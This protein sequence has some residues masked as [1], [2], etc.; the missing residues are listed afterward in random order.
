MAIIQDYDLSPPL[1]GAGAVAALRNKVIFGFASGSMDIQP[2]EIVT[3]SVNATLLTLTVLQFPSNNDA[4]QAAIDIEANDF[5]SQADLNHRVPLDRY[6]NAHSHSQSGVP[7]LESTI[8]HGQYIV[9][10]FTQTPGGDINALKSLTEKAFDRQIAM[11]DHLPPLSPVEVIKQDIDPDRMLRR[12]LN[13]DEDWEPDP[14]SLAAYDLQGFLQFQA[15]P[16]SEKRLYQSLHIEKFGVGGSYFR[17]LGDYTHQGL[18]DGFQSGTVKNLQGDLLYRSPNISSAHDT[19]LKILNAP[20][21]SMT[22]KNVPDT[23]CAQLPTEGDVKNFTCAVRYRQYVG[24][25]WGRQLD[26]AQQRA[27]AQY[28]LLANSQGM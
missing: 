21:P 4:E 28:A 6:P 1:S 2:N 3:R 8:A 11:L 7:A 5:N 20:D 26:D 15:D 23:K 12:L 24:L 14:R 27:A 9:S 25:V 22:P 19:W 18:S 10:V 17:I 16:L 13:P